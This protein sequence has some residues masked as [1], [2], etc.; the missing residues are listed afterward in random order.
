MSAPVITFLSDYGL[1]DEFVG[2]CHGVIAARCPQAR[3]IDLTHGIPRH[4]IRRGALTLAAALPYLPVGV[5]LAVV[6]PGVGSD[7]R[8]IA[9]R[10][11]DGR[12]FVGPDNGLLTLAAEPVAAVDI[13]ASA[14]R[15]EPVSRTFH[16][17]DLFAPV[18]AALAAGASLEEVGEPVDPGG[19]VRLELVEARLEGDLLL[20]EVLAVDS[21]GNLALNASAGR[22]ELDGVEH[23]RV[24]A[25]EASLG[26][27]RAS[28]FAA[29]DEGF[30]VIYPD[31]TGHWAIAVNGGS[32]AAALGVG[33]GDEVQVQW[34]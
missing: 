19:L 10:T 25:G 7:R 6:D 3:I 21:F 1:A 29:V 13:G 34:Q 5:H 30:G 23:A 33:P 27:A 15:L 8:A 31:S 12:S 18:A 20:A 22:F 14:H 4:D 9:L 2:V 26:V 32:A 16:G 17:R 11:G 28:T 24:F